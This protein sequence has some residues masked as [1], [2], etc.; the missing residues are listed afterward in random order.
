M[1]WRC[2]SSTTCAFAVVCAMP[3]PFP[4]LCDELLFRLL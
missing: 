2:F 3:S 1:V 4:N